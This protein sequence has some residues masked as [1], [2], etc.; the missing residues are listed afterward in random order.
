[1]SRRLLVT[2][3]VLVL[4]L[5]AAIAFPATAPIKKVL[6]WI[7]FPTGSTEQNADDDSG[8]TYYSCGMHPWVIL[9]EPG[10]CPVCHMDLTPIDPAKFTGEIT[11]DPVIVQNIGVR[12][13]PVT[14]GELVQTIRTVG[15]VDYDETTVRDVNIKVSG[16]IE[17]LHVD[18]L[19]AEVEAGQPLFD[20]YSPELYEAQEEYLLAYR[21]KMAVQ[22]RAATGLVGGDLN[23]LESAR[24]RLEFYDITAEQ[25]RQLEEA[26]TPSKTMT[27]HSPHRGVVIA[28]HANEGMRIDEGMQV[29]RIADLSKVWVMVSLYERQLPFA[30]AGQAAVMSLSYI[31]GQRFEGK[32]IYVYPYLDTQ[33]RQVTVRLE[34]D[35]PHLLLKPG[36]Y[37]NV[38]LS[39][40]LAK[41][42]TLVPRAAV[43]DTGRRQ[44]AFVSLGKGK[45][46]PRQ[47]QVGVETTAGMVEV[48]DG[49]RPGEMVVTSG[50]FL[51]DSEAKIREGLAKM[52]RGT[53]AADQEAVVE[54]ASGTTLP[55]LRPDAEATTMAADQEAGG[56]ALPW[57]P[58]DAEATL[59]GVLDSYFAI[60]DTLA[61]DS[62]D[63]V[64]NAAGDLAAGVDRLL[65]IEI[66][67]NPHF[68]QQHA[69]IATVRGTALE[70]LEAPDIKAARLKFADLS[71][72][73]GRLIAATGVPSSFGTEVHQLHCPM[74]RSGQG[75]SIWLQPKGDVR[76]P[77]YGSMML[78]CFDERAVLPVTGQSE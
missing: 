36:M 53:M 58:P 29:Y 44:I 6:S 27:I 10:S 12:V 76:N 25:I 35:N 64:G 70:L 74:F 63:G 22:R 19:G 60:A 2:V 77:F 31:P 40:V 75:G 24:T 73:M 55:W 72:A 43:I 52:I 46:E 51:L 48:L 68:W 18:S 62:I 30:H 33:T 34:F 17:T 50:Q 41:E 13:E 38:E 32:I 1:M 78:E 56:T 45:F 47:L 26:N 65:G 15:T 37:A 59:N 71:V 54:L 11:I 20:L 42:R 7:G 23:L 21:Q 5:L 49:L 67:Q 3:I 9:P 66:P 28:K 16:W 57:L 69:E 8:L 4:I 39:S 61:S 14:K